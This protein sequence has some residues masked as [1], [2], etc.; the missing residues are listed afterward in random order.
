MLELFCDVVAFGRSGF[1]T[2]PAS[3]FAPARSISSQRPNDR[4]FRKSGCAW[5]I[6]VSRLPHAARTDCSARQSSAIIVCGFN[7]II[8]V[9]AGW[10]NQ[11]PNCIPNVEDF[12]IYHSKP[13]ELEV[14]NPPTRDLRNVRFRAWPKEALPRPHR[15][16]DGGVLWTAG[17]YCRWLTPDALF[18][19]AYISAGRRFALPDRLGHSPN[20]P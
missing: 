6:I 11:P 8:R 15:R 7:G 19:H 10:A 4:V 18:K 16:P 17:G 12:G 1:T 14:R 5:I 3:L 20:L 9:A 2:R 13:V